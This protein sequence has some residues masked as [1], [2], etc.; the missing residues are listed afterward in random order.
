MWKDT[1][2]NLRSPAETLL[3]HGHISAKGLLQAVRP[4]PEVV[5]RQSGTL[6]RKLGA[7]QRDRATPTSEARGPG[8]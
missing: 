2:H 3:P 7:H 5:D 6:D 8:V 1:V 4:D